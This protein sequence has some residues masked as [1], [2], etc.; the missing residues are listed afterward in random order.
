MSRP[1]CRQLTIERTR[2]VSDQPDAIAP[3]LL[4]TGE[5]VLVTRVWVASHQWTRAG[6]LV[7]VA[8]RRAF[9]HYGAGF[10][11]PVQ[12]VFG[13]IMP[14]EFTRMDAMVSASANRLLEN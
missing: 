3:E 10:R 8:S 5:D 7:V 11:T 1:F 12:P 9:R 13:L 4:N 6:A 14:G 2:K